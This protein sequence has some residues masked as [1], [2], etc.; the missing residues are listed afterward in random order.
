[1]HTFTDKGEDLGRASAAGKVR[2][3]TAEKALIG[4]LAR[5][6]QYNSDPNRLLI[7]EALSSSVVFPV[8]TTKG[9]IWTSQ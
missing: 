8:R 9:G 2:H 5:V 6:E 7:V 1:M 4:L 3:Q